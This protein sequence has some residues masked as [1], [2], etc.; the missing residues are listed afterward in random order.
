VPCV[1]RMWNQST[2]SFLG[3]F[4]VGNHGTRHCV[5]L[6]GHRAAPTRTVDFTRLW[7]VAQKMI[8]KHQRKVFDSLVILVVVRNVISHVREGDP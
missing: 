4:T 8:A 7:H 6:A 1:L 2:T 5:A 3:V